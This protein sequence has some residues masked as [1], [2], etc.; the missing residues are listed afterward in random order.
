[1]T[2][3][4]RFASLPLAA[5]AVTLLLRLPT[6]LEPY[7]YADEGIFA[8]VAQQLLHGGTLYRTVWDDKPPFIYWLYAAVLAAVGPSLPVLR[9]AAALWAALG[10]AAVAV[11]GQRWCSPRAGL[12]AALLFALAVSTPFL[13]GNLALTELFAA[14]PVAWAF[15][16]AGAPGKQGRTLVAG[17]LLGA[18]FLF[19]QVAALDAAALGVTL[20][21]VGGP[22]H[23]LPLLGGWLM[24]PAAV[25]ALLA[26]QGALGTGLR[27]MFGF[28]GGYLAAGS[29][30]TPLTRVLGL[31]P[32]LIALGGA[33]VAA[34]R[35]RLSPGNLLALWLA[36][37]VTG[38]TLAGRW[39]G[40]YLVQ[41]AAP[42]ALAVA[43]L[44]SARRDPSTGRVLG[45]VACCATLL[46]GATFNRFWLSYPMV[47]PGYYGNLVAYLSGHRSR[48][49]FEAFFDWRVRAQAE[50]V[51]LIRADQDRTLFIWG[52]F[53]WLYA[54]SGAENPTPYV[55][56]YHTAYVPGAKEQV[57]RILRA[58]PPRFIVWEHDDWRRL[59]GLEQLLAERY[60]PVA[61]TGS[62]EL[63]R[64]R[65]GVPPSR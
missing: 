43:L 19:K 40:H 56:S 59:P 62:T 24:L 26:V 58:R 28:Y 49:A 11:L 12:L 7:H 29:G 50:L 18:A 16:L 47:R 57:L 61:R 54:L 10:A 52:E 63:F 8:A 34:H 22:R 3:R 21:L 5:A 20:L 65:D 51:P 44:A 4:R 64:R 14:T 48:A 9:L 38:A 13:E 23:V 39:Y 31:L 46:V 2:N 45:S 60:D 25:G 6:L 15:V 32:V 55:T 27:A 35:G 33:L 36:V 42:A 41:A 53:P 1:M 30:H 17:V 37:A